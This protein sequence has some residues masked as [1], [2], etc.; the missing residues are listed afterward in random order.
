MTKA[1]V[2]LKQ[3]DD[4]F[5]DVA[6]N[7][8]Q[9]NFD[10]SATSRIDKGDFD[11]FIT[12]EIGDRPFSEYEYTL[13]IPA[14]VIL[15]YTWFERNLEPLIK[16]GYTH[17]GDNLFYVLGDENH[18][19]VQYTAPYID[20]DNFAATHSSVS[21]MLSDHSNMSYVIHNE[22][23]EYSN[24][25]EGPVDYAVTVSSGFF[26]NLLLN[27]HDFTD[28]CIVKHIDV[29]RMSLQARQYTIENW[30]GKDYNAWLDHLY[31]KF[32]SMELFNRGKFNSRD[33]NTQLMLAHMEETFG[34][35]WQAH[36]DRYR[37]LTHEYHILNISDLPAVQEFFSDR[38]HTHGLIW[39]DGALK[40]LPSNLCKT[41]TDS[42]DLAIH[43]TKILS[44]FDPLLICYGGDHCNLQFNGITAI[45]TYENTLDGNSREELW[46]VI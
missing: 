12:D 2:I 17:F 16:Q 5:H 6:T 4:W 9:L 20:P 29:S 14:G 32:P 15:G 18:C 30:D 23:P 46:K 38:T 21:Q 34:D 13:V 44:T 41:S 43:F 27:A 25:I 35:A 10:Y 39:W 7:Y 19:D 37:S 40:R 24:D 28:D 42:W 31:E 26:I 45:E 33:T 1:V 8:T 36:W 22:L 3:G 11:Y